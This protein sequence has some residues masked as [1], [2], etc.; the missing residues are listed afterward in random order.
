MT[1]QSQID[2][3]RRN[4]QKSTGPVTVTGR[5]ISRFN[6]LKTGIHAKS[7]VIPGENAEDLDQLVADY[8]EQYRPVTPE[9]RFLVDTMVNAEWMLRRYHKVEADLWK[10]SY[11][12]P[13]TTSTTEFFLRHQRDFALVHRKIAFFE[14]SFYSALKELKASQATAQPLT[15][16]QDDDLLI[17]AA[18]F[19][20]Q[21]TDPAEPPAQVMHPPLENPALRL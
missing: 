17:A 9:Q 13:D 14:R 5:N 8:R 6:A 7:T 19:C 20:Q 3:N 16:I 11:Q 18:S 21:A 2:A 12:D 4:A 1:T 10:Y 15:E